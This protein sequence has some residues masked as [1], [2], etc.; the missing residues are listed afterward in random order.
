MAFVRGQRVVCI[1]IT[2]RAGRRWYPHTMPTVGAVYT[3][4]K[5][6]YINE[7]N[8]EVIL[9]NEIQNPLGGRGEDVGYL[10]RRFRPV[11]DISDLT[12]IAANIKRG[13]DPKAFGRDPLDHSRVPHE[14]RPIR[15]VR[16]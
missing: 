11:T 14:A 15:R 10:V 1:D 2:P 3:V 12:E 8:D 7:R 5:G 9:L 13:G 6:N 16:A 4:A